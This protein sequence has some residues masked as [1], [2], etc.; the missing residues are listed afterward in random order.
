MYFNYCN[1]LDELKA[2][3]RK[4]ALEN[5][6]DCGG[7]TATM[8]A[9]NAEYKSRF[10][11]LK[12]QHNAKAA[13][14]TTGKTAKTTEAPEDFIEIINSLIGLEGLKIELCGRWLWISGDTYKHK[15]AL[16]AAGCRWCSKKKCWSWHH[17]EDSDVFSK[18]RATMDYI[19]EKY[20]STVFSAGSASPATLEA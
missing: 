3:Y 20:G 9:I 18:G 16:K 17:A 6:P 13:A 1:T 4:A 14:D 7:D 10:E 15:A 8:Q 12:N 5:H 2:A 19:R 11:Q